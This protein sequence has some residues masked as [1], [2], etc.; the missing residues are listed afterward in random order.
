[1][2]CK[3]LE[4]PYVQLANDFCRL[5]DPMERVRA[6]FAPIL[7]A[8]AMLTHSEAPLHHKSSRAVYG[9]ARHARAPHALPAAAL[10]A[11]HP[12]WA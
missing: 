10:T 1:M 2:Q 5:S 3:G 4:A 6:G 8:R 7:A 12:L 11:F 9:A